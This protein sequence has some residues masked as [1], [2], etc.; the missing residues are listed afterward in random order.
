MHC[1]PSSQPGDL[2]CACPISKKREAKERFLHIYMAGPMRK[3]DEPVACNLPGVAGRRGASIGLVWRPRETNLP[4][5]KSIQTTDRFKGDFRF[6]LRRWAHVTRLAAPGRCVTCMS[7]THASFKRAGHLYCSATVTARRCPC[8]R[9]RRRTRKEADVDTTYVYNVLAARGGKRFEPIQP[10]T[11][12]STHSVAV[13]P[14]PMLAPC[15][16]S[17]DS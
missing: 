15:S 8:C 5:S 13:V 14:V 11:Q 10:G 16:R 7:C 3:R 17:P 9:R 1:N 6:A 4:A 12:N 2:K